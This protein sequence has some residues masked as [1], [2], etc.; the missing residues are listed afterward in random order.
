MQT[1]PSQF[2]I[3]VGSKKTQRSFSL[4]T[5]FQGWRNRGPEGACGSHKFLLL[6]IVSASVFLWALTF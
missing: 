4:A 6:V 1:L 5:A 3:F 2:E